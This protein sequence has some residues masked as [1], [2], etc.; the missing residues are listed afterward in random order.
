MRNKQAT[1]RQC[2]VCGRNNPY[3]LHL[4]FYEV[5]TGELESQVTIPD[6]FQGYPGVVHGGI[7]AA[8]LDEVT[9][10]VFMQGNPNRFMVTAKLDLRYRKPV[11]VGQRLVVRSHAL[12]DTGRI[13]QASGSIQSMEGEILAEAEATY[14]EPPGNLM[15]GSSPE[16]WGWQV[17]PDEEEQL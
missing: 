13:A 17:V 14:V 2:F 7:I 8:I 6:H 3:G 12:R 11:P 4:N 10:R 1:S 15:T 9:G 5:G 16:A